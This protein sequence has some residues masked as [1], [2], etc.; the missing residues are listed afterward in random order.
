MKKEILLTAQISPLLKRG[1]TLTE[2][3]VSE[4]GGKQP[5]LDGGIE[6]ND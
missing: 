6:C 2:A 5:D 3:R 4:G 1:S